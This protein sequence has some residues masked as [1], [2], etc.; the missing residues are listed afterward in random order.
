MSL[1]Y[2]LAKLKQIIKGYGSCLV[3]FS[4]GVD[5]SFL[6]KAASL[7]LPKDKLL[8]VTADSETYPR[9][10]LMAAKRIARSLG[11][12]HEV[13]KTDE[14]K[15]KRF[16]MNPVN[17]CYFCKKEL[18]QSLKSLAGKYKLNQVLDASTIS[19][20]SDF[21]P[22]SKAKKELGVRSPLQEAG[23]TKEDA[24]A[25][26]KKLGLKTWDKPSLACLASRIPYGTKI[27]KDILDRVN[28]GEEILRKE[29]F[30]QVRLRHYDSLCRIEVE[31]DQIP[32]LI[33]KRKRL[34]DKLRSLGYNY[35][36]IDLKGY[37]MGSL[38]EVV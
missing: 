10:E 6:L 21:R 23:F 1:D 18:F 9:Q 19:D 20:R 12:K 13:I 15:D 25:L 34:V 2:K 30:K 31:K 38:N 27:S 36:T 35:I 28:K 37:R 5:S 8:A 29:G 4:G 26:S 16:V 17:R 14:L 7:V 22:G 3:A 32:N 33:S 11:V 24:R